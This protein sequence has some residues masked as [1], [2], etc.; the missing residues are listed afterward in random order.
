MDPSQG[1]FSIT[2]ADQLAAP[3]VLVQQGILLGRLPSCQVVL[4]HPTVSRLHAGINRI[5]DDYYII[6]L[7]QANTL[8]I[9]GRLLAAETADILAAGDIVEIGP[10]ELFV[11]GADDQLSLS[12]SERPASGVISG[13]LGER[14]GSKRFSRRLRSGKLPK[15]EGGTDRL[16]GANINNVLKVFWKK[17]TRDRAERLTPLHPRER[18][19]P[20]KARINW[21]PTGDLARDWP[22]AIF[23]WSFLVVA[24]LGALAAWVYASAFAPAPLSDPHA[25]KTMMRPPNLAIAARVNVGSCT[26]CH[27]PVKGMES[28]CA[29]CHQAAA[30]HADITAE[31]RDAGITCISCHGEHQGASFQPLRA[32][33]ASCTSCHND[34]NR[35]L[36]R[37]HRVSTPH[38]GTVGYPVRNGE[39]I[40]KGLSEAELSVLPEVQAQR[41]AQDGL[42]D[43]RSK[44]FHALH[45]YRVKA[46]PGLAG[47][48]AG[49]LSCST[50]HKSFTPLD[51]VTPA[52]TCASC[53]QQFEGELAKGAAPA[54]INC[55]SC[56]VQHPLDAARWGQLL[57]DTAR[58]NRT[59]A[60][61][62]GINARQSRTE[63]R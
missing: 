51:R 7:S 27:R 49:Q 50:C 21:K 43:W 55:T 34:G 39:W 45:V 33:F 26:T 47:N 5:G 60:I 23:M 11:E 14:T 41:N 2:R 38:G 37:G 59:R 13:D 52:T 29:D 35:E 25:R 22:V 24:V 53:H 58:E 61:L 19:L 63:R 62:E 6:N 44:Q 40:W 20:G 48:S 46:G 32:G 8:I 1:K 10:F 30:F 42:K 36:Y 56:H 12:I 3:V 28:A 17:R 57:T 31:H 18:P 15:R 9:N 16:A 54:P 4:N